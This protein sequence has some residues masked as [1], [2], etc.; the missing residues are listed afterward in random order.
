MHRL[1]HHCLVKI[2]GTSLVNETTK[3]DP[4]IYKKQTG[5]PKKK[6]TK[7]PDE[8]PPFT[9]HEGKKLKNGFIPS[10]M[11]VGHV[12]KKAILPRH[13]ESNKIKHLLVNPLKE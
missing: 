4:P 5:R 2:N 1:F 9:S 10:H 3:I 6:R 8:E 7:D 13:V 11:H 12:D